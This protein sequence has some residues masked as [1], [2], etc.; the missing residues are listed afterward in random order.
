MKGGV[1][2]GHD[3][4]KARKQRGLTQ[5]Q[6]AQLLHVTQSYVSMLEKD[7]RHVPEHLVNFLS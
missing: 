2:Q 3:L 4:R 6:A 7:K 5:Q 1:V